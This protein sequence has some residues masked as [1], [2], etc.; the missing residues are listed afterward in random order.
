MRSDVSRDAVLLG[1]FEVDPSGV[2]IYHRP[3]AS[4][5]PQGSAPAV[6]GKNLFIDVVGGD[7]GKEFQTLVSRFWWG[8]EPARALDFTFMVDDAPVPAKVL[9]ARVREQRDDEENESIFVRI[10]PA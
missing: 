6:V 2:V 9:L 1:L 10:K 3:D 5:G 7:S 4:P 8:H